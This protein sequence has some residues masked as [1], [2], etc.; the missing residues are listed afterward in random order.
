MNVFRLK[1][2]APTQKKKFF[3]EENIFESS[4]FFFKKKTSFHIF[5]KPAWNIYNSL[6]F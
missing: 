3:D 4:Y 2:E 5:R 6:H 1:N